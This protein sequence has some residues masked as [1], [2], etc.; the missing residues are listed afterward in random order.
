MIH[1]PSCLAIT[2]KDGRGR[3]VRDSRGRTVCGPSSRLLLPIGLLFLAFG[4]P[5]LEEGDR[6]M[7]GPKAAA[8]DDATYGPLV[9][10]TLATS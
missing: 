4:L 6:A 8:V 7:D 3:I 10:L 5:P 1:G 2:V 9:I